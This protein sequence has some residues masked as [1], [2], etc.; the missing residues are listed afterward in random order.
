MLQNNTFENLVFQKLL[1]IFHLKNSFT[2]YS[3]LGSHFQNI[4]QTFYPDNFFIGFVINYLEKAPKVQFF[5]YLLRV[6][7]SNFFS[8]TLIT[9]F[10]SLKIRRKI[11]LRNLTFQ[12]KCYS[13]N[14]LH[15]HLFS[16]SKIYR[17]HILKQHFRK[18]GFSEII[19]NISQPIEWW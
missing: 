8:Q 7:I 14:L 9:Q 13:Q 5:D 18:F 16:F 3:L 12:I 19:E 4:L 2:S 10:S 6:F 1:K 15:F 17:Q 11:I